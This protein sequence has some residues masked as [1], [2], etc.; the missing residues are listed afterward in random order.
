MIY[1]RWVCF[2]IHQGKSMHVGIRRKD[3]LVN[4]PTYPFKWLGRTLGLGQI[5]QDPIELLFS[6]KRACFIIN[7]FNLNSNYNK[8]TKE[9]ARTNQYDLCYCKE[10]GK[11]SQTRNYS[12]INKQIIYL[13]TLNKI[14][15]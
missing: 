11:Y 4:N 5:G 7:Q 15:K 2:Y 1:I 13:I 8:T 14:L 10:Y 6:M 3:P 12:W 9:L